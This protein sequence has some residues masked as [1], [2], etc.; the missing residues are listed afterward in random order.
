MVTH[1][2]LPSLWADATQM[3]Q[4]FQNL[5]GNAIKYRGEAP[6][7]I[8]IAAERQGEEWIFSVRDNGIGFD[9]K[10][11]GA[12]LHHLSARCTTGT[13]TPAPAS[14]WR[15]ARRSSNATAA[16]SGPSRS[17]AGAPA[18]SSRSG[19]DV[20]HSSGFVDTT[21]SLIV[22]WN[23]RHAMLGPQSR[24]DRYGA[25]RRSRFYPT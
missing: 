22:T 5:I 12:N 8:H 25:R 4:L 11:A 2:P 6:P 15:S 18:S 16:E 3:G 14:A 1:D 13:N 10:H 23:R 7:R 21:R 9:P 24:D 17:R 20:E 19:D